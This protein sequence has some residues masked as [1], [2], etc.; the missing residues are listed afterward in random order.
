MAS[1]KVQK[2]TSTIENDDGDDYETTQFRTTIPKN[3]AEALDLQ[4]GTEVKWSIESG[5]K[6]SI[7][8]TDD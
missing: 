4:Q 2:T 5:K 1:T 6:L 8:R 3:L 7:E